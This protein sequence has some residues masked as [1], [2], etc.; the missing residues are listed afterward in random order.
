MY[1]NGIKAINNATIMIIE[2]PVIVIV[3][4]EQ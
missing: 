4:I 1:D 3:A 2:Q